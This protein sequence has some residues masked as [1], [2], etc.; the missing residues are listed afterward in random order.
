MGCYKLTYEYGNPTLFLESDGEKTDTLK[1]AVWRNPETT[2]LGV[3]ARDSSGSGYPSGD[4][5]QLP[6][7]AS[8]EPYSMLGYFWSGGNENGIHY[9]KQGRPMYK[10]TVGEGPAVGL[11]AG[12]QLAINGVRLAKQLASEAQMA[13]KGITII[14]SGQLTQAE[15]L[16]AQYGGEASDWVKQTSSSYSL[17]GAQFE[18]HWYENV[19]NFLRV[20]FKT[21]FPK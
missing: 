12:A 13:E 4:F 20:E 5:Y 19:V 17:G 3:V 9:D 10:V 2:F 1:W 14:G 11:R 7:E 16:A 6:N 15:R 18:T 21:V 8:R